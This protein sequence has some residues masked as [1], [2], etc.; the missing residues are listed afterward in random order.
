MPFS[1]PDVAE[2]RNSAVTATMMSTATVFDFG[3]SKR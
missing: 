3:T 2:I 1:T